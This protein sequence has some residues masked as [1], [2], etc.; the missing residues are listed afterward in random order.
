MHCSKSRSFVYG[1]FRS[2]NWSRFIGTEAGGLQSYDPATLAHHPSADTYGGTRV[3]GSRAKG[4]AS[5]SSY[6]ASIRIAPKEKLMDLEIKRDPNGG[7]VTGIYFTTHPP[8]Y[9]AFNESASDR[10]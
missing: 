4:M 1:P 3:L 10:W 9:T 5:R 8:V 6:C 2:N 7:V